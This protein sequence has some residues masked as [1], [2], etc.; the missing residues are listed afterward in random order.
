MEIR[1]ENLKIG[2]KFGNLE[3]LW[4]FPKNLE[5]WEK[6]WKFANL[7]KNSENWG[8]KLKFG[9]NSEVVKTILK[10][11]GKNVDFC[12]KFVNLGKNW[13]YGGNP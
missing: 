11:G 13:K 6:I 5:I 3:K 1:G 9:N 2:R 10:V 7:E 8:K 4:I 12:R